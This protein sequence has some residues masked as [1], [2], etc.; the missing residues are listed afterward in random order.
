MPGSVGQRG[1]SGATGGTGLTGAT[2]S[3]GF[4]GA[5]GIYSVLCTRKILQEE[6]SIQAFGVPDANGKGM[7]TRGPEAFSLVLASTPLLVEGLQQ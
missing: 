5:T 1:Q 6:L 3:R 2:G 7:T 4:T